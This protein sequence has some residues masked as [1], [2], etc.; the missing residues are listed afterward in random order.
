MKILLLT[1]NQ[2][3]ISLAD[4]LK[5]VVKENVMV[6]SEKLSVD[7][8]KKR[9]PDI[10]ISYN[11]SYIIK[12]D[13]IK[14]FQRK[15]LINL[16]ISFLP[17]NR[18]AH[19]NL[20]SFLKETPKGVTIHLIDRGVDTGDILLQSEVKFNEYHETLISS[21]GI[22]HEKIQELFK[23][24]W[25]K[26]RN[27]EIIPRPQYGEGSLHYKKDFE[28]IKEVLGDDGWNIQIPK[29][30]EKYSYFIKKESEII[31]IN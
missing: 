18:G 21:Y 9:K 28:R 20:W 23:A 17:W 14:C 12:E 16:H 22:L 7:Y 27:F 29:L 10:I 3:A 13:V 25:D 31:E 2:I 19:P 1:N 5:Y 15:R 26:I 11:Y 4:W 8:V 30:K 6:Y 24:N